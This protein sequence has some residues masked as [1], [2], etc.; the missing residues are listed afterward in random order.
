MKKRFIY[1]SV[2]LCLLPFILQGADKS[3]KAYELIYQDVQVLKQQ[4]LKLDE[5]IERN[6]EEIVSL[7]RQFEELISLTKLS[8]SEQAS[9]IADQKKIPIQYQIL[10][11]KFDSLSAELSKISE[12][13]IEIQNT[14]LPPVVEGEGPGDIPSEEEKALE[15]TEDPPREEPGQP[16]IAPT[17]SPQEVYNMARSDYLKGNYQLAIEGFI[18][19]RENFPESPVA[20]NALYWIGECY[21]S[22][23]KFE[24]AIL[25]FNELILS[26]PQGDKIAAAYLKKGISLAEQGKKEESLVVFKLL[27]SKFPL[28]E[29]TKIAQQKIKEQ[30]DTQ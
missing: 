22:Q 9:L 19:Y 15:G 1:G 28:E 26:Y 30:E 8:R 5:K 16:T 12:R 24:E 11:Q 14:A 25:Q 29:E 17:L 10:L 27:I 4:I 6:R 3:K 23:Q 18:I 7:S 21:F 13:L 20:D 2:F